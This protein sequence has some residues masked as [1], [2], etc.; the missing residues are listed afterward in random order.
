MLAN[1]VQQA[2]GAELRPHAPHTATTQWAR[3]VSWHGLAASSIYPKNTNLVG[4]A[5]KCNNNSNNK[6][7]EKE[8]KN[9]FSLETSNAGNS[10]S[11][12][13]ENRP[14]KQ[15]RQKRRQLQQ[16]REEGGVRGEQRQAKNEDDA[17]DDGIACCS[18]ARRFRHFPFGC[19][20]LFGLLWPSN[21]AWA[22]GQRRRG[23][24]GGREGGCAGVGG[25]FT[26][27]HSAVVVVVGVVCIFILCNIFRRD[28]SQRPRPR[29]V[30]VLVTVCVRLSVLR[31]LV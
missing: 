12:S 20:C 28:T 1:D 4:W 21:G 5:K 3:R 27:S 2:A 23:G 13:V 18:L 8:K 14:Q 6:E 10:N 26:S 16:Q 15:P 7:R 9:S 22:T 24:G 11:N 19:R 31:Y 25:G 29:L 17:V 30:L